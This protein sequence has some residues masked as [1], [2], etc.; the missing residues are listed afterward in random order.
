[1]IGSTV[2]FEYNEMCLPYVIAC[3]HT[4][5]QLTNKELE[6]EICKVLGWGEMNDHYRQSLTF[7][8]HN[9]IRGLTIL[10]EEIDPTIKRNLKRFFPESLKDMDDDHTFGNFRYKYC[11]NKADEVIWMNMYQDALKDCL[12]EL[13]AKSAKEYK[14]RRASEKEKHSGI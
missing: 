9:R 10:G 4:H 11:D 8:D 6:E 1:M 13:Q 7:I 14:E 12:H 5:E 3:F 2:I